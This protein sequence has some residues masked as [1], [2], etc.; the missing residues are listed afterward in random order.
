MASNN[1]VLRPVAHTFVHDMLSI[2]SSFGITMAIQVHQLPV[3]L[4]RVKCAQQSYILTN[5]FF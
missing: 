5:V 2:T 1:A 3:R 4:W